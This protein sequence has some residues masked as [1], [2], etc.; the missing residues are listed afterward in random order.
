MATQSTIPSIAPLLRW[1]ARIWTVPVLILF[2]CNVMTPP[3]QGYL[4]SMPKV[5]WIWFALWV[6]SI[7]ALAL[8]WRWEG[9]GGAVAVISSAAAILVRGFPLGRGLTAFYV[10]PGVLFLL[11]WAL[12]RYEAGLL[13]NAPN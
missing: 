9:V 8:A 1:T 12:R 13:K 7:I 4:E 3:Q 6:V 5:E 2:L 11:S 10:A